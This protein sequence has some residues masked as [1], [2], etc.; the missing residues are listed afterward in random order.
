MVRVVS[1]EGL[2]YS[3]KTSTLM[4]LSRKLKADNAVYTNEGP[5]FPTPLAARLLSIANQTNDFEREYIYTML[6]GLDRTES[7]VHPVAGDKIV[8]QDRYWPS[9][10]AYGRFLNGDKSIHRHQ[11]FR[12]I[13]IQ[14]AAVVLLRCSRKEMIRRS[15]LR[16]RKSVIDRI[17][18]EN[19]AQVDRLEGEI[20][21]SLEGLPNIYQIDTSN[22]TIESVGEEILTFVKGLR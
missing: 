19:P 20:M 13:F 14:P 3:G 6:M 18:L 10:I 9:V 11:D 15:E 12:P 1:V 2:D 8:L 16:G 21:T 17:L 4:H 5:I 7:L 22:K